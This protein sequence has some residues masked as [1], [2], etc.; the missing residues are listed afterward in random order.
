MNNYQS[1]ADKANYYKRELNE[2]EKNLP[3]KDLG[4]MQQSPG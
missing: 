4:Y 2:R 3:N 1:N